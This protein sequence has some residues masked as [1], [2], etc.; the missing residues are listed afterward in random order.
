MKIYNQKNNNQ[1][2]LFKMILIIDTSK[3]KYL[4]IILENNN[5][6]IVNKKITANKKQAEKLLLTIDQVLKQKKIK[7]QE[8]DQIKVADQGESSTALRIGI[9]VANAL[10]YTLQIPISNLKKENK[11]INKFIKPKYSFSPV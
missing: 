4:K 8:I 3:N 10:A 11:K 7:L 1:Q 5:K 2:T 9:S 6:K